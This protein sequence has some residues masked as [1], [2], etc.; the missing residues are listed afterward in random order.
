MRGVP[1]QIKVKVVTYETGSVF[2]FRSQKR[3]A[4]FV[5]DLYYVTHWPG[6]STQEHV[7]ARVP[8]VQHQRSAAAHS[9][10]K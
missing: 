1:T 8:A 6:R 7:R 9:Q 3:I 2:N 4:L 10:Q 5:T